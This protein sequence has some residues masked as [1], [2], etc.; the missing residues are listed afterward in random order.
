MKL[1]FYAIIKIIF[2]LVFFRRIRAKS[3]LPSFMAKNAFTHST[4]DFSTG[5]RDRE[6]RR[7]LVL[8][9][10]GHVLIDLRSLCYCTKTSRY[11]SQWTLRDG[12]N[13][14][15]KHSLIDAYK[16]WFI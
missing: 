13:F 7:M 14:H 6:K 4:E 1:R 8:D 16:L 15:T 3:V 2:I 12:T 10:E 5:A 9:Q 11:S